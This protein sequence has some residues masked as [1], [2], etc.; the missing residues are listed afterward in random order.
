MNNKIAKRLA[1]FDSS[2]IRLAFELAEEIP[3]HIDLSIG[4]PED[5]TPY[6]IKE[7][8]IQAIKRGYTKYIGSNGLFELRNAIAKKLNQEN[9]ITTDAARVT[10]TPGVTTGILLAYLSLLDPGDEVLLPDPFFPPYHDIAL[11]LGA[12]LI[13]VDT[14]PSF[15]LTADLIEPLITKKTKLL[16][17]NS[18]NNPSGAIYPKN[19]LIKI[20]ALA[21][22]HNIIVI[23]DE[24]YEYFTY[25]NKHFSIGS[26]YEN[27][28]TLNGVSKSYA[29]TGWRIGYISGPSDI[30]DAINEL[31]QYIVF[32]SS[33]ISQ[34]A[35]L[36]ALSQSP[37]KIINKYH[38]KRDLAKEKL[39]RGFK[40]I[41]GAEGAFYFFLRLPNG[42]KDIAFVNHLAHR[43]VIILP[44]SAFSKND[45]YI[46][47]AFGS[48]TNNL[49]KGLQLICESV[50]ILLGQT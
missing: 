30:I 25:D 5:D 33:S 27:T 11:M 14:A 4:Y 2:K 34:Y 18:P 49:L 39:K 10:I 28:L 40:D 7:A 29:M 42:I 47:V 50:D 22:K 37:K 32:S 19:E 16:V 12:Q 35:A 13:P 20:A 38:A 41:Q 8:G 31:Q 15:Q 44:G 46:R 9:N 6:Y 21:R 36:A 26:I 48:E 45:N 3:N 1:K 17:I 23:S 24:V 43:G